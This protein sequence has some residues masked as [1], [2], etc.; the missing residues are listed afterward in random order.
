MT[1]KSC[2]QKD[3]VYKVHSFIISKGVNPVHGKVV[4]DPLKSL[5]YGGMLLGALILGPLTFTWDAALLC[6]ILLEI[7]VCLGW[8]VGMHRRLIHRSFKCPLWVE[9]ILVWF[10]VIFGMQGPFGVIKAHDM[11]DWAQR[12]NDCHPY[13]RH[14]SGLLKDFWWTHHYRLVLDNPPEFDPGTE[15]ANDRFYNFLQNTWM[16]QQVP[17]ALI[18]Y[19]V[20]GWPWIVWGVIVR[21]A[22]GVHMHW[23]VGYLCHQDGN[24]DWEVDS[25]AVQASNFPIAGLPSMGEAYHNNHHAFPASAKLGLFKGQ[26]DFGYI[27]VRMLEKLGLANNIQVPEN[28]PARS[29]ILALSE[30]ADKT[31]HR[32]RHKGEYSAATQRRKNT[33]LSRGSGVQRSTGYRALS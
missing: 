12:Q 23:F 19:A 20:G 26:A 27:F 33:E 18:F 22:L 25:A 3:D 28:L 1:D 15:I 14:G 7:T 6:I 10:G 21:V 5:W 17:L 31:L 9:R 24:K 32:N 11:R 4:W 16:L 13:L 30:R 8:S 2:I 29:G